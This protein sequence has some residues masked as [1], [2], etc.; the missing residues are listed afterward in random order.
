M[1][2]GSIQGVMACLD[3]QLNAVSVV[4]LIMSIGIAVEFCVHIS[5]AFSVSI[6]PLKF[7]SGAWYAL[8]IV[9]LLG[10]VTFMGLAIK[11][12]STEFYYLIKFY[13]TFM[14]P[15]YR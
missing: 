8:F 15:F 2:N 3:I 13:W 6:N 12:L 1:P 9:L 7:D 11:V 14:L 5:H 10:G 4:N